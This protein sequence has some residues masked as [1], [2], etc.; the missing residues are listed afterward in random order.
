MSKLIAPILTGGLLFALTTA[1]PEYKEPLLAKLR[2]QLSEQ[3][4]ARGITALKVLFGLTTAGFLNDYFSEIAQNNFYFFSDK[5]RY[6]WPKE[7]A[8]ITGGTGGFGSLMSK[9]LAAKGVKIMVVDLRDE[10]PDHMKGNPKFFYYKCDITNSA[11]VAE[12]A[13][14]IRA[15]HGHPSILINNAGISGDGMILDQTQPKLEAIFKV[16]MIA[17]YYTVQQFLPNMIKEKKGHVVTL[18]SLSSFVAPPAL[19]PYASTKVAALAF[20]EG[21]CQ[22]TRIINKA[23]EVHFTVV[24]PTFASTPMVAPFTSQLKS[25]HAQIIKPEMVSNTVVKQILACRGKQLIIAPGTSAVQHLRSLPHWLGRGLLHL[26]SG[27]LD[28]MAKKTT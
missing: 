24:H 14:K 27:N 5:H 12:L 10:L 17:H 11:A 22:E 4:I 8:V 7:I 2:E 15:E 20:H 6:N 25:A 23:P 21:L 3:V 19:V 26:L 28:R 18:A 13:N 1:P 16:N 9:E